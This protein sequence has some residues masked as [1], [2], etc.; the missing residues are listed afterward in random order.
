MGDLWRGVFK[1]AIGPRDNDSR[2]LLDVHSRD[3]PGEQTMR[4]YADDDEVD[5]VI[6]GAGAGGSVLAQRLAR[7]GWRVVILEAGP[8][9]HPD[10]DWVSDEA[11]AHELYWTQKRIIG[12]DDPIELGKNNSGRGVG[13][14]MVHYA[15]YCPRFHPSDFATYTRDGVGADWP[16]RYQDLREHYERVELELPVAGQNWPW[17]DPHRYPFSPHPI[18]GSAAKIWRGALELG[19]QMRVGPVGIVN[20]TFGNRPHCI[21]RGYCLQGCKVH[22]KASPYVT[23]LPDALAHAV[24]IR[25]NCMAA[26]VELDESGSARGVVYYDT[27]GGSERLQKAKVVA[28]AGYSIET[29]RLLLNSAC[30]G[31][32]NGLGNND[33][34]VGRY[35]MVQGATQSA[36]R[37]SEEVRMYKAPPPEVSSEQFYETDPSRGFARGFAIQTVSPMPIGWAE[38]VLAEGL[39][40]R[41]MREYMRDYNHWAT[42]GVLNELLPQPDNRV[43]LATERDPY[44]LPVARFDYTLCDNDKA[45]MAYST[46]VIGDIL[47]A[48]DAQDILTI[49]R[50][51][52]LIGGARMGT[53]PANSVV[54]SDHRVWGVPNLLVADG[55]VCP[56]QGSAN[57]ALTIM[58][59]ASRLAQ[60]MATGK[61]D[62]SRPGDRAG[63]RV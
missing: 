62:T 1:G 19:I 55:S 6:V 15:G 51:A 43:T 44:G 4:R 27:V 11:G 3:L 33:D 60:R 52:H 13:G 47:H 42:V 35:V 59:L 32:P 45:N 23:H 48:A 29:P 24:E 38:H 9:W 50:F 12:G 49:Q 10:E 30:P 58:A 2:F 16:I 41:A 63:T 39:W 28:V 40:G 37:W 21:Y 53:S 54:D 22:A 56:T 31:F 26:R 57:P 18:S 7:A 36:G 25:A 17:G 8:F 20:G 5:L 46:K 61:I 14:S 34:Q